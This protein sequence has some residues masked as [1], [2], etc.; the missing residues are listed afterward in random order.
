MDFTYNLV[1]KTVYIARWHND[2]CIFEY[3]DIYMATCPDDDVTYHDDCTVYTYY[4]TSLLVHKSRLESF[5][6]Y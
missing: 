6:K 1:Q 2:D 5:L 4:T 3:T